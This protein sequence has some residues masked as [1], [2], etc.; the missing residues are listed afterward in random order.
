MSTAIRP[1]SV[2]SFLRANDPTVYTGTVK[3]IDRHSSFARAY[4][5]QVSFT[6]SPW[7]VTVR[8][9]AV[10]SQPAKRRKEANA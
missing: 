5:A 4:G 6:D 3:A 10:V 9:C 1:G 2:V 8:D 7:T